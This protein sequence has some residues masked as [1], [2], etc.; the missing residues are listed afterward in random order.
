MT[1]ASRSRSAE[2]GVRAVTRRPP[3]GQRPWLLAAA[4]VS[5][6][7]YGIAG[8]PTPDSEPSAAEADIRRKCS[9]RP[10]NNPVSPPRCWNEN[11]SLL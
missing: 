3:L 6:V 9:N 4:G 7:L 10:W 11:L 1:R 5:L 8:F 2:H